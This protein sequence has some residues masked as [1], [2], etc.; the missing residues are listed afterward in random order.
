MSVSMKTRLTCSAAMSLFA[1]SYASEAEARC[2]TTGTTVVCDPIAPNPETNG[3]SGTQ[4]TV[5]SGAI[6]R[7]D[8]PYAGASVRRSTIV[9]NSSGSLLT[10]SGSQVYD[11]SAT[12]FTA[13]ALGSGAAANIGGTVTSRGT[14]GIGASLAGNASITVASGGIVET[15][16]N[17]SNLALQ[18]T[19][20]AITVTGINT[21]ITVN[22][23]VRSAGGNAPAITTTAPGF[24]GP[25]SYPGMITVGSSGSVTTAGGSSTA[26]ALSGGSSLTV[27]GTVSASGAN[28]SAVTYQ[29]G[30]TGP[31]T[32]SVL[33]GGSIKANSAAAIAITGANAVGVTNSLTNAGTIASSSGPGIT[34]ASATML[35]NSGVISGASG[36]AVQ[37][38]AAND[39]VTLRTGS[40]I[41]GTIVGGGGTDAATLVGASVTAATSQQVAAFS[42]FDSLTVK[43][44]YWT[45]SAASPSSFATRATVNG[46]ATLDVV[47]GATGLAL[48]APSIV[49]NGTLVVRSGS[50][51]AGST[52]GASVVTGMGGVLFTGAGTA[53][54]DGTNSLQNTGTNVVDSGSTLLV[55]GTQG[56]SFVNNGTVQ[57]GAGGVVGNITGSIAD[58]GTL[59]VNRAGDYTFTGALTGSGTFVEQGNGR[60]IFGENYAFN[61]V[62]QLQ[63]G[64]VRFTAPVATTTTL[65]VEGTGQVDMSGTNQTIAQ[66]V[67]GSAAVG[68]NIDGGSLTVN[69]VS[70]TSFT[71]S[72]SGN[73]SLTKTGTGS[74]NLSGANTYTGATTVSAGTLA[75]GATNTIGA[76]SAVTVAS[77]ATLNVATYNDTVA[78]LVLAGTLAGSGT[79]TAATYALNGAAVNAN[80]GGGTL[81][82]TGGVST[83]TGTEAATA[84]A[85]NAGTLALGASDRL[86]D[87]AALT[88]ASGATLDLRAFSDTV[89]TIALNG[90]LSGTGTLTAPS[91]TLN[92]ATVNANLGTGTLT[93]ASGT[94]TLNG[95][96]AAGTVAISGGTL[97]T[98][99]AERIADS[100]AVTIATG[101]L[102]ALGGAETIGSLD[103]AGNVALGV[104]TLTTGGLNA[105]PTFLG[106]ISGS[107]GLTKVG[108]GTLNLSGSNTYTGPTII[109][110]G[111]L[112][113]NGSII[114]PVFVNS[115]GTLGGTGT[116]GSTLVAS[117]GTFAPGNSIG[118]TMVAGNVGFAA[119]SI[120]QVEANAAGAAD[121]INATGTATLTGG[122][123]QVLAAAGTYA[124]LTNYTILTAAGGVAG[125]FAAATS[126]LAFLTPFL[127]YGTNTVTLQLAR[128]DISFAS[129][130]TASNGV[131]VANAI[132]A[133]GFGDTIYNAI[134][135]Q[136]G[137]SAGQSFNRLSGEIHATVETAM[138]DSDRRVRDA[139]MDRARTAQGNGL[140]LWMQGLDTYA[141]S[142]DQASAFGFHTNRIG[143]Y[144]GV[145]YAAGGV[146]IGVSG[147]YFDD[148]LRVPAL[149]SKAEIETDLIGGSISYAALGGRLNATAGATHAWHHIGTNRT[150]D[151]PGLA[152]AYVAKYNIKT[153]Q[154]FGELGFDLLQGLVSLTPFIRYDY[155]WSRADGFNEIGGPAALNVAAERRHNEYGTA[156]ARIAASYPIGGNL[157]IEPHASAAYLRTWDMLYSTRFETF[158]GTGPAFG[159]TGDRLGRDNLDASGGIDLVVST[160]IRIGTTGYVTRSSEWRDYGGK[161]SV[162]IRF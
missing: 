100:A 149:A 49:D 32:L 26:I 82:Q 40:A 119:G 55:T 129:Q 83:L 8:D 61:G 145:D 144:G 15:T 73:G 146:R 94:S 67:S 68:I 111:R 158:G 75:L 52:F 9:V 58:N 157:S 112:A 53:T 34:S 153:T 7:L 6:V 101:A 72:I 64:V 104:N 103:G 76:G 143:I 25:T 51:S 46:N 133:R 156:G 109:N 10:Q 86:I 124:P 88:V 22:G 77:G 81:T 4:I 107:G 39:M 42:G 118:T 95:V 16:G 105:S 59:V 135:A 127:S 30:T 84:V 63:G 161:G 121:R 128:N 57:I 36:V 3:A 159:V 134:L 1:L 13:V 160:H 87:T 89:G 12:G 17:G 125:K 106:V 35:D 78:S 123:V 141:Y 122:T 31:L 92:A 47:N 113:V 114:S 120:Y 138:I 62:T 155:D 93:Q 27:A 162:S 24:F 148:K 139:I 2:V 142:R 37:L 74:L 14:A 18:N 28:S 131:S 71:G 33:A 60:V 137:T 23:V 45:V 152:S 50:A 136:T 43:S 44:G 66:L 147:G 115:G 48:T 79:L 80:L 21:A 65:D 99:G 151:T 130:A 117:G 70:N 41:V 11:V 20:A 140:G 91:Y 85:V 69:Q 98:G 150:V 90:T 132:A 154:A 110:G 19:S 56:G 29:A 5:L 96:S 126:N 38:G 108:T 102:L 54:L 97:A 116:V